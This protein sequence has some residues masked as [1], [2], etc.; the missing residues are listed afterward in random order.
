[1]LARGPVAS[2]QGLDEFANVARRK[3][4]MNWAEMRE[5]LAAARVLLRRIVPIDLETH[6]RA[7]AIAE[8]HGYS[9]FDAL[10]L[11]AALRAGCATMWSEVMQDGAVIDGRLAIRNPFSG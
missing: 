1:L 7:L 3:L 10:M 6:D 11:A 9:I 2:V 5:A 4:A 8:R